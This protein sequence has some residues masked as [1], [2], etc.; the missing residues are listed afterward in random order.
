[1]CVALTLP[2]MPRVLSRVIR[3]TRKP[4]GGG[5]AGSVCRVADGP[6]E[7]KKG[8]RRIASPLR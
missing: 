5:E 7:M 6:P 2:R 1:M 4:L 8:K 3:C